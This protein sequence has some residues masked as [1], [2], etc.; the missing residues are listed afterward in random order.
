VV[1][2]FD[3]NPEL[4]MLFAP[5][6]DELLVEA[7]THKSWSFE[8]S[9]SSYDRLEFLGDALVEYIVS[10]WLFRK[11]P[12]A[13][14][15]FLSNQRQRFVSTE[16]LAQIAKAHKLQPFILLGIGMNRHSEQVSP[17]V[18]ADVVESLIAA[19]FLSTSIEQSETFVR[20]LLKLN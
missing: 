5:V 15:G 14:E 12:E 18:L 13:D 4:K 16:Y 10:L 19:H 1:K 11:F 2:P 3:K 8:N 17:K 6:D 20:Q 7:L 9:G